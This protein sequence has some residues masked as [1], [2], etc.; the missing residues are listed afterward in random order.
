MIVFFIDEFGLKLLPL[1]KDII[2]RDEQWFQIPLRKHNAHRD[3]KKEEA[4]N[5]KRDTDG[6]CKQP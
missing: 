2:E 4:N 3:I 6:K 5:A 1:Q